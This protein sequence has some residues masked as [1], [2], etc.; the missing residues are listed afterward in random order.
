MV[1]WSGRSL[2]V[3]GVAAIIC[4]TFPST[5]FADHAWGNYHWARTANPFTVKLGDNVS[6]AWDG[7]LATAS[8]DWSQSSVLNTTVV[9]GTTKPRN[10]RPTS[11]R[12]QVC[13]STYGPT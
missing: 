3:A 9:A 5:P 13:N 1:T 10:C 2:V 7:A 6:G 4:F 12:V 11:G 8:S